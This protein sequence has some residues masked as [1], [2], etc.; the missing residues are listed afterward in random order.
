[1]PVFK[2]NNSREW[3]IKLTGPLIRDV[4]RTFDGLDLAGNDGKAFNL[5][6][7]DQ[8]LFGDVM[9]VLLRSQAEGMSEEKFAEAIVGDATDRAVDALLEAILDFSR[10]HKRVMLKA[11]V[12]KQ[13][14]VR[15][16]GVKE[17]LKQFDDPLVMEKLQ[18]A[19]RDAI[20]HSINETLIRLN[21][22]TNTPAPAASVPTTT[23]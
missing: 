3:S 12:A 17:A 2:D 7:E 8:V 14:E 10:S 23:G 1:M 13:I 18:A 6:S 9:W 11:L 15:E 16:A 20:S 22:A 21:S 5:L 19:Q 4:R